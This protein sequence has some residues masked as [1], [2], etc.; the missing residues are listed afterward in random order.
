ML[1][2][3]TRFTLKMDFGYNRTFGGGGEWI[4]LNLKCSR[5][6]QC[7]YESLLWQYFCCKFQH[8]NLFGMS[9][10]NLIFA[11]VMSAVLIYY[12]PIWK[13]GTLWE[14]GV[15]FQFLATVKMSCVLFRSEMTC[16]WVVFIL[17]YR[18]VFVCHNVPHFHRFWWGADMWVLLR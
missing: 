8:L 12:I 10:V 7:L 13:I 1:N 6:E 5:A 15:A 11:S 2:S 3:D 18:L 14:L 4:Q 9:T 16:W 17:V